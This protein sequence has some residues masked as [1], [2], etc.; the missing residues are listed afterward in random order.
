[1]VEKGQLRLTVSGKDLM[2]FHLLRLRDGLKQ[3]EMI[4]ALLDAYEREKGS[5]AIPQEG[6]RC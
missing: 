2:R 6:S 1:M 3:R 5:V 4:A